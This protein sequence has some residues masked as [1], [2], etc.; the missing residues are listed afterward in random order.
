MRSPGGIAVENSVHG[1]FDVICEETTVVV[2][3]ACV[4]HPTCMS[5]YGH[6]IA[7][8]NEVGNSLAG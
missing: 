5:L 7:S 4:D 1:W 8:D 3:V 6:D 2:K